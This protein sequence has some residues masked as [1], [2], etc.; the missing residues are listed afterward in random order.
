MTEYLFRLKDGS[1]RLLRGDAAPVTNAT[2]R[3]EDR[4]EGTALLGGN[5][6]RI[7]A[8]GTPLDA[9]ELKNGLH[10]LLIFSEGVRYEGPSI[11]VF[12]GLLFF[13]PPSHER[14]ACAEERIAEAES[15]AA[16]LEKRLAAIEHRVQ[17]TNIF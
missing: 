12:S 4:R 1:A 14:L 15:K 13:L 3:L 17:N 10:T 5:R 16:E 9:K 7:S 11:A 6:I 8:Q 2:L